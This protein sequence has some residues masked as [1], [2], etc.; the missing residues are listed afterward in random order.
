MD[1][2]VMKQSPQ[3]LNP[4]EGGKVAPFVAIRCKGVV[5]RTKL[6]LQVMQGCIKFS[7]EIRGRVI[8]LQQHVDSAYQLLRWNAE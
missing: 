2:E 4:R 3:H 5:R 8:V 6:Q 1:V 7:T